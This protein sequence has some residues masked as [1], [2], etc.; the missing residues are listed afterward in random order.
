[1]YHG[2]KNRHTHAQH[3]TKQRKANNNKSGLKSLSKSLSAPLASRVS[4]NKTPGW[5]DEAAAAAPAAARTVREPSCS[6]VRTD[7]QPG[8]PKSADHASRA[9]GGGGAR[10]R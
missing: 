6:D 1:M 5:G 7:L 10:R 8:H 3:G 4:A 2:E 9:C